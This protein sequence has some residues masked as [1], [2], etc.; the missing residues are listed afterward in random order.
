MALAAVSCIGD[1][2]E[3]ESQQTDAQTVFTNY[4]LSESNIFAIAQ[5]CTEV[6]SY[7]GRADYYYGTNTDVE[8]AKTSS[9]TK[10]AWQNDDYI[11]VFEYNT[12]INNKPL[13]L[14]NNPYFCIYDG[15]ERAN[16]VIE[17]LNQFA[18][19]EDPDMAYLL[20]EA[21]TWRAFFYSE[22]VKMWGE[23]PLRTSPV[24]P[25]TIYLPKAD[26]DDIYLQVLADLEEAIPL[27][28]EPFK[29]PQTSSAFR[30]NKAMACGLY[31]RVALS[32]AGYSWRPD[33][34][35]VGTGN[36]GSLRLSNNEELSKAKLYPKALAY[37]E[38][39]MK[40][41]NELEDSYEQ[42]WRKFNNSQHLDSRE[43]MWVRPY[44]DGR[45]RW[46]YHHAIASKNSPYTSYDTNDRGGATGPSPTLWWKY[47]KEDVRRDITCVPWYYK[48]KDEYNG[49][50]LYDGVD[51]WFWGKYR[52]EWM[53]ANPFKNGANDDGVKPIVMRYSDVLL[54]A[55]ELAA[56]EGKLEDAKRYL[57][58]VRRRAYVGNEEKAE[59]YVAALTLGS[60]QGSDDAAVN[61]RNSAG[62]I[63]KAIIDERA[64]EL[65]GEMVRKQD[66]IRWGLLKIKL[67]EAAADIKALAEM[68]GEYS[69]YRNA[70]TTE[71]KTS[72]SSG[73]QYKQYPVFWR[74]VPD[75]KYPASSISPVEVYGL[76]KDQIGRLPADYSEVEPN[77]WVRE[78]KYISTK[79]FYN[80]DTR[81]FRY[82]HLYRN[83]FDDPYPRSVWPHFEYHLSLSQQTVVNDY[84][85]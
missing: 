15:I 77:G 24:Q 12:P 28:Y 52:F 68:T 43:V 56:Y 51:R 1:V 75:N 61:D 70:T 13:N 80:D 39:A 54:M 9:S 23:A 74:V 33:E 41:G 85:Y 48:D 36:L 32:A 10:A 16:I 83:D 53:T 14:D 66:L 78:D 21:L 18:N 84:L 73:L 17:G 26:R 20:G 27:L 8:L 2:L 19:L 47:E 46:N 25:E 30:V 76:E 7:R 37:L 60:A 44:S 34:G 11:P 71:D 64:L 42:L 62:T 49:F 57:L 81:E 72:G 58:K 5:V 35:K 69:A 6:N 22:L 65:A 29:S 79:V 40:M 3:V 50:S 55:A 67:D 38:E 4:A 31:A 59:A 82:D 63:M 45:G